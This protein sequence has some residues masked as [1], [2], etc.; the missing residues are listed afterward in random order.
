MTLKT[1]TLFPLHSRHDE[2]YEV[3]MSKMS[4]LVFLDINVTSVICNISD[5]IMQSPETNLQCHSPAVKEKKSPKPLN[6]M[7][8]IIHTASFSFLANQ[9]KQVSG[10]ILFKTYVFLHLES[11]VTQA[12][13]NSEMCLGI[14]ARKRNQ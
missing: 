2:E 3:G 10:E 5:T 14:T 8:I 11:V 7:L 12:V 4:V 1:T 13:F 9:Y 6:L